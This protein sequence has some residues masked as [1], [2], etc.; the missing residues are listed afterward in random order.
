MSKH[1]KLR[2]SRDQWK[3]KAGSRGEELRYVRKELRRVKAQRDQFKHEAKEAQ[4]QLKQRAEQERLPAVGGKVDVV[5]IALQ[6]FLVARLGFRAVSRVLEVLS[7]QLGVR[8][9]PC[10]QTIINWVTR[11]SISRMEQA[12]AVVGAGGGGGSCEHRRKSIRKSP[13]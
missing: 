4:A 6:L 7:A 13:D 2:R 9:A 1:S 10:P 11:L 12:R 3:G 8:H 5:F